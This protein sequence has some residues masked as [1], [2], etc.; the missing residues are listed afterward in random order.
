M[1][2][3]RELL[4]GT[5]FAL[6]WASVGRAQLIATSQPV[7]GPRD[8]G[9]TK[10]PL[11]P[12]EKEITSPPTFL[13][14]YQCAVSALI[15]RISPSVVAIQVDHGPDQ[16]VSGRRTAVAASIATG[17]G[18]IIR[19]DGLIL[20]SH[21]VIDQAMAINVT[22][23]DGRRLRARKVAADS[24]ADLAVLRVDAPDL[25]PAILGDAGSLRRGHFVLALGNPLGLSF[26]GQAAASDGIVSAISRPLPEAFGRAE[27]R[28][29][30]DMIQ[31]SLSIQPGN[32]GGPL[33]NA[34]A[35]VVGI[36]TAAG[37]GS[38]D[39]SVAFAIPMGSRTRAIIGKLVAGEEVRYGYAGVRVGSLRELSGSN[40]K[41][42]V[43]LETVFPGGPAYLA[44]L[45]NGDVIVRINGESVVSADDFIQRI[46]RAGQDEPLEIEYR[47][48]QQGGNV[49]V[50]LSSRAPELATDRSNEPFEF[51]GA[52]LTAVPTDVRAAQHLPENSLLVLSINSGSV[53]DRAGLSPGDIIVRAEGKPVEMAELREQAG[54]THDIL[55]GLS[56]GGSLLIRAN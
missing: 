16:F 13:E 3:K 23:H 12:W 55:I 2:R 48:Q 28:Y 8:P 53:S 30:G 35:E 4:A 19:A 17:S 51:R 38:P 46:G 43:Y 41:E 26:D 6:A 27:D 29:Y 14:Q 45:R 34:R 15:A 24:R 18:V 7:Y 40:P 25:R 44:G 21:H 31:T 37:L 42:G 54:S 56:N 49:R 1:V 52:L 33:I 10:F 5:V 9:T 50:T 22:L 47:R 11:P 36:I 39:Q 20:T 32:S